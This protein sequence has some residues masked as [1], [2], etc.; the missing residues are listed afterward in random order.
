MGERITR[1]KETYSAAEKSAEAG[2]VRR[3]PGLFGGLLSFLDYLFVLRP[4]ILIPVWLFLLLGYHF[5][6]ESVSLSYSPRLPS[7]RLLV[8][9]LAFT[10]LVAGIYIM[11]QVADRVSDARNRKCF[12]VADGII[13][14]GRAWVYIAILFLAA[15]AVSVLFSW[16]YR[17]I[18]VLSIV[19]GFLYNLRPFHF[20][21]RA[22]LDILSNAIGNGLLNFGIGWAV[23]APLTAGVGMYLH[24]IPYMLAVAGVFTNTTV[25]DMEGDIVAGEKTTAIFM[26]R[27]WSGLLALCFMLASALTALFL[28]D[29]FC[30]GASGLSLPFFLLALFNNKTRWFMVS[31]KVTTLIFA[32]VACLLFFWFLPI[33][34]G[35]ILVT[36]WYYRVRFNLKYPF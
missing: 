25:A 9:F 20:K 32:L 17:A 6:A 8:T 22:F 1:A 29:W 30:L 19:L 4:M 13:S 7:S 18:I 11:N 14:V 3:Y 10:G 21:G 33:L 35:C 27:R 31:Y 24:A 28:R 34:I 26:G 23:V 12:F 2:R 36:K 16:E 5:G 15:L